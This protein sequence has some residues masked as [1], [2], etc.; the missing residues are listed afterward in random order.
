MSYNSRIDEQ[1]ARS[2]I[3]QINFIRASLIV[4]DTEPGLLRCVETQKV[5]GVLTWRWTKRRAE[6]FARASNQRRWDFSG[7]YSHRYEVEPMGW[8]RYLV[9]AKQNLMVRG[10]V[11]A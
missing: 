5:V 6:R 2:L 11:D 8:G 7:F 4:L 3:E 9:V 1:F 10:S